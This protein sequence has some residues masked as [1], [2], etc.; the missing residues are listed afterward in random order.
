MRTAAGETQNQA[1]ERQ[2][3]LGSARLAR[4][5]LHPKDTEA[6]EVEHG[7]AVGAEGLME[8]ER[9]DYSMGEYAERKKRSVVLEFQI[10]RHLEVPDQQEEK[11]HKKTGL[12]K[13]QKQ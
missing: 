4:E 2:R 5:G 11:E 1:Q 3:C 6:G 12:T 7:R 13:P 9:Q 8:R 10:W